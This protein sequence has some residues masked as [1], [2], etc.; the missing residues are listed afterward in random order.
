[1]HPAPQEQKRHHRRKFSLDHPPPMKRETY[2]RS[3]HMLNFTYEDDIKI[4]NKHVAGISRTF[5]LST[6]TISRPPQSCETIPLNQRLIDDK[7]GR[8]IKYRYM[9]VWYGLLSRCN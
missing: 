5:Y 7:T 4:K 6:E 9:M 8:F 2:W 3:I 1:M